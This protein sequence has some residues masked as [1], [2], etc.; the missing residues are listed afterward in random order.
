MYKFF[1][2]SYK[3]SSRDII[4]IDSHSSSL[5]QC[6]INSFFARYT[7]LFIVFLLAIVLSI[8]GIL[9]ASISTKQTG[10]QQAY[11]SSIQNY[12]AAITDIA[13][14]LEYMNLSQV[15]DASILFDSIY[16]ISN[17]EWQTIVDNYNQSII[18]NSIEYEYIL[19]NNTLQQF[20]LDLLDCYNDGQNSESIANSRAIHITYLSKDDIIRLAATIGINLVGIINGTAAV[21]S[22]LAALFASTMLWINAIAVVGTIAFIWICTNAIY[23]ATMMCMAVSQGKGVDITVKFAIVVP[24]VEAVIK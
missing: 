15:T 3:K 20:F 19:E 11:N 21:I 18:N 17:I 12:E 22:A 2:L 5:E 8:S 7:N 4:S 6:T 9:I 14:S 16:D 10:Q 13:N 24:Y 23:L 1:K